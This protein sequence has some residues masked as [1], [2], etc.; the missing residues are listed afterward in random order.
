MPF[1]KPPTVAHSRDA[2]MWQPYVDIN[3][4]VFDALAAAYG[5]QYIARMAEVLPDPEPEPEPEPEPN[6]TNETTN[7]TTNSSRCG[8]GSNQSNATNGSNQSNATNGSGCNQTEVTGEGAPAGPVAAPGAGGTPSGGG[9]GGTA[10]ESTVMLQP[11]AWI[12]SGCRAVYGHGDGQERL[13]ERAVPEGSAE[14]LGLTVTRAC[15][16]SSCEQLV[17][18]H[19]RLATATALG[20]RTRWVVTLF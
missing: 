6:Q 8:N 3:P 15:P 19:A 14:G 10:V 11:T 16:A 12:E 9:E 13:L 1:E 5:L 2:R 4:G 18:D 20:Q 7:E 17:A